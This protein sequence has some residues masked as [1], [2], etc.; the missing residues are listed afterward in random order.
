VAALITYYTVFVTD[1]ASRRVHVLGSTP[2]PD[3]LFTQQMVRTLTM[4]EAARYPCRRS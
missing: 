1:L 3:A 4:A 2:Y